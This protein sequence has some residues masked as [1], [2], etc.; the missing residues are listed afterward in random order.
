MQLPIFGPS[1]NPGPSFFELLRR[2]GDLPVPTSMNGRIDVPHATT[3][4]ALRYDGG[5]LVAGDRRAT[6]GNRISHRGMEKVVQTDTHSAVA[7]S[8]AA[9]AATEMIKIF[10][11]ELEHYEK[12]EGRQLTLEGKANQLSNMVR[13][14]LPAAMQGLGVVMPLFAGYDLQRGEGRLWDY[15]AAGGRYEEREYVSIGSGTDYA[16]TVVKVGWRSTLTADEAVKL[17]C[18]ALWEAADADSATG[19]PDSLRGVYPIV[20]TIDATGW[21]RI[22]D[23]VLAEVFAAIDEEVRTR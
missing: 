1:D 10:S 20:A 9:S 18:R 6:M 22:D 11:L 2:T 7:I 23:S 16:G 8:G 21:K 14:N 12:M 19:G 13:A 5:V 4:V 15:D 3:C 17:A